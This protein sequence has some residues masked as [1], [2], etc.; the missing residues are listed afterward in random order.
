MEVQH[1]VWFVLELIEGISYSIDFLYGKTDL[2][3]FGNR[4]DRFQ[5]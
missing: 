5:C 1:Q 3:S 4:S 2:T